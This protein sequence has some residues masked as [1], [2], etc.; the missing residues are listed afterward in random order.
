M[1]ELESRMR[2][3]LPR[4]DWPGLADWLARAAAELP[5]P[6]D[7]DKIVSTVARHVAASGERFTALSGA[8][9]FLAAACAE[10][11]SAALTELDR[12]LAL[13]VRRAVGPL[14]AAVDDVTQL[15]R[16]RLLVAP[17]G[18]PPRIAEYAGQGPLS[19]WLRAVAVRTA[20]NARR[21]GHRETPVSNVPESPASTDPE[22]ALLRERHRDAFR[23]AFTAA[24]AQ[25]TPRERTVLRLSTVD[26][27]TLARIGAIYRKDASTISRWLDAARVTLRTRTRDALR[28]AVPES[29]LD[30]VLRAADSELDLS[31]SALLQSSVAD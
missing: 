17:A 31:L 30:S 3:A 24:I 18:A 6:P 26:G 23:A 1:S 11:D 8:D 25:L 27:L 29:Q 15:V 21:G 13:E 7:D 12:R 19:A 4:G 14:D 28:E 9:L 22:L 5:L 10:H 2:A 20:L 16:E